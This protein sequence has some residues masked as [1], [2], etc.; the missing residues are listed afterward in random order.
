MAKEY[1]QQPTEAN[2]KIGMTI[3]AYV[4]PFR[5]FSAHGRYTRST[6]ELHV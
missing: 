6:L 4:S 5:P 3:I 1:R 2:G